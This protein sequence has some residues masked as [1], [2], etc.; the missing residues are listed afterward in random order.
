MNKSLNK[1]YILLIFKGAKAKK[2]KSS[3]RELLESPRK[4][5]SSEYSQG[6]VYNRKI[7]HYYCINLLCASKT[8]I[9]M[10]DPQSLF[11]I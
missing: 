1:I 2:K 8:V 9:K 11:Q 4:V 10:M 7:L 6:R 5:G 3:K